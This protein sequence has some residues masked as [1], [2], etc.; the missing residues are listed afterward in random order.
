MD[1]RDRLHNVLQHRINVG[2]DNYGGC[3]CGGDYSMG[4]AGIDLDQGRIH[5]ILEGQ[6]A[7]GGE[8]DIPQYGGRRVRHRRSPMHHRGGVVVGGVVVGG[9]GMRYIDY[10]RE[11]HMA[12]PQYSWIQAM[13]KAS[14]SYHKMMGT[15]PKRKVH[16][17]GG[18]G[19]VAG[20]RK[21]VRTKRREGL[22]GR[23]R[24]HRKMGGY[25]TVAGARKAVRTKRREGLIGS[26]R[27]T[28]RRSVHRK[29]MMLA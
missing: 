10:V 18:Y 27:K 26:R 7:M 9:S 8:L 24:K 21:A 12:H 25:G 13:K 11:W 19:T 17:R 6:I 1:I 22:I 2:A 5:D 29:L 4:Q 20:A 16:K 15:K 23:K 28:H 14:P 3:C